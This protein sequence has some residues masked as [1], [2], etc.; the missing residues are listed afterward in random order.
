MILK[1]YGDGVS[2]S[3]I[4]LK[5]NNNE[6]LAGAADITATVGDVPTLAFRETG[7]STAITLN[8]ETPV[9]LGATAENATLFWIAVP[10]MT[11]SKGFTIT[12]TNPSG[13]TFEKATSSSKEI[14]RNSTFRMGALEVVHDAPLINN[15]I[16]YT[17]FDGKIVKPI[18]SSVD[19]FGAT[20]VSNEYVDG[21]GILTFDGAVTSI[22][23]SAFHD[24]YL[25]SIVIP[26]S[27]TV[28]Q[29]GAF[30]LCTSLASI[31]IPKSVTNIMYAA[32]EDCRKLNSI[33]IP[34]SV[35]K[36]G[37]YAFRGCK[38]LTSAILS[39]GVADVSYN[40]F[41]DCINLSSVSIPE[42]VTIIG[43]CAFE[44]C[45]S[46]A[47]IVIPER[48]TSIRRCAFNG[49]TSLASIVIPESVTNIGDAAFNGC[50]SLASI[51]ISEGVTSIGDGSFKGCTSLTSVI[52][53]ESVTTIGNL[54]FADCSC[55][56]AIYCQPNTPPTIARYPEDSPFS[57]TNNCSI[58]VPA[59]A[60]ETYKTDDNWRFIADRIQAIPEE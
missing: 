49:C 24:S 33:T 40:M 7:T 41:Q 10:P 11:F 8:C 9:E 2:V 20:I 44:G 51:M 3:S 54:A 13:G 39:D 60:L 15:V 27:V 45:T 57:N 31:E 37:G 56:V 47:S 21:Q 38:R 28:I 55:L 5:G 17:S 32:F 48:V 4:T 6:I 22:G 43:S 30:S 53:P 1:L 35:T 46:L 26:E 29:S 18:S 59:G 42:S 58:Y 16:Y 19:K 36:I 12:V 23:Q 14:I 25:S 50:T 52:I 34:G